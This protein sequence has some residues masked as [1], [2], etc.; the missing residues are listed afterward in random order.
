MKKLLFTCLL[1]SSISSLSYSSRSYAEEVGSSGLPLPRFVSLRTDEANVRTGPGM[2]YPKKWVFVKRDIPLEIISEYGDWRKVRDIQSD[3]G[4]VHK[5][6]LSGKR[7]AIVR[8]NSTKIYGAA[9]PSSKVKSV[10][11]NGVIVNIET[12]TDKFCEAEVSDISGYLIRGN[13]WG[14]YSNE[15]FK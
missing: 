4:W 13:V 1:L 14:V 6:M 12:C 7:T 11:E 3:D 10:L 8:K 15:V 9:D 2:Q 5:A